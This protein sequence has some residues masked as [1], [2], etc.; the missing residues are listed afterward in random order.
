MYNVHYTRKKET[1]LMDGPLLFCR[2][3]QNAKKLIYK[4]DKHNYLDNF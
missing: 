1:K 4:H 3:L 2:Q